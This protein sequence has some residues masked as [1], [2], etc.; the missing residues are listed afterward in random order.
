MANTKI[1]SEQVEE[2]LSKGKSH[3][4]VLTY[5]EIMD[6]MQ[7]A[8][9]MSADDMDSMYELIAQKGID[10]VDD[11][12]DD[13]D[14]E[15]EA[16]SE[17]DEINEA[18]LANMSVP[19]GVSIDDPV[20]MYLKEIGRV[21]LL[22]GEDEVKLAKRMDKGKQAY[23][24]LHGT[25]H[26]VVAPV[27]TGKDSTQEL[28]AKARE[29][30]KDEKTIC[31]LRSITKAL[32][33][34]EAREKSGNPCTIEE[35]KALVADFT[36]DECMRLHKL[37]QDEHIT[38]SGSEK[39]TPDAH[40]SDKEIHSLFDL[41][42]ILEEVK[43]RLPEEKDTAGFDAYLEI[44]DDYK[45]LL[46]E[47]YEQGEEAKRCL[48]EANLRLVVSIAKRYVGRGMLFLDLIQEG[49]L[50][51]IKAV[52]KF[53]YNKGFKFSTY[54]TWWIRQAITRAI[55]D[56]ARTIRIPVHMVETIN[57]M[58]KMQRKLTLELGY[59]PSV[60]ELAEAL[61]MSEDKVMEIMQ[62]AREPASLETPIGEEDD[63][64]LGDFVADSN[65]V[66]PEGN[67]ESVM[68]REHIDA[69]LGDLKERE[70]Q[71]IVLRFGLE[72]G[73]PRT[74]EEVG[75]EFNV[76]RERIRQ[77]EAKALR[78]LRHPSRSRKLKD[79]LD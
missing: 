9:D 32:Q 63:S 16:V 68:L 10:V 39:V 59:E 43:R 26:G 72:D 29:L 35:Y 65:A 40:T 42:T 64:N 48:S 30:I 61:E 12:N 21:P 37:L 58:S 49:N 22:V 6:S 31:D 56:Q 4:G 18:E 34:I 3:G 55:A 79:Y 44:E 62:I 71:V 17:A 8:E 33:F 78:K 66:T 73:H 27:Y 54:A 5:R 53:D 23:R 25:R 36:R 67:V 2:L 70:R 50:G 69:L 60:S 19:E 51:L 15:P 52:E 77:I 38:I 11:A 45:K 24:L 74:L 76:T 57:K 20:R 75:K 13:L 14:L 41:K 28:I 1:P 46:E 7:N 47:V